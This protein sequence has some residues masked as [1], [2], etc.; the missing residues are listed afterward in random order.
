[1]KPLRI[2]QLSDLH[3][4]KL[5]CN[6]L[7][8]LS[9]RFLG[10]INWLFSRKSSYSQDQVYQIAPTLK[11][12]QIDHIFLCGDFTTTS[13]PEEF[14]LAARF[15]ATL[16]APWIAVPG[17]HDHY[18]QRAYRQ[19]RFYRWFA[20][21]REITHKTSFFSL[22][23]Q[24]VEAHQLNSTLSTAWWVVA[25]DTAKANWS[26]SARGLFSEQLERNLNEVLS[27]IPADHSIL[28]LNHYPF[29]Q[30][31][32]PR[33]NLERGENL[34]KILEND[35]RIKVYLH[36][37]T[38]QHQIENLQSAGLPI[39]L[40]SGCCTD[41]KTGSWNVL[42]IDDEGIQIDIYGFEQQWKLIRAEKFQWTR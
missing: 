11:T 24:G 37:H 23:E 15:V 6:P 9:K 16:P 14:D 38:H 42:T 17:N 32:L 26:N 25:L 28:L 18:T 7:R 41:V 40:D 30:S 22:Q 34:Q 2:A 39:V 4:T 3:L 10:T 27:L 1:M 31:D 19:K 35:K 21:K 33:H 8:L 20:N 13:L 12:L 29:F 5:S 36:G